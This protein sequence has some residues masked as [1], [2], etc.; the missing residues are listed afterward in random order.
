MS[1]EDSIQLQR[2]RWRC[3]RGLLELDIVLGR[4]VEH[5]YATLNEQQRVSFD[6]LLDLGDND[7]WDM[8]TGNK[9]LTQAHQREVLDWLKQA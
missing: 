1:N 2:L 3:R 7:L 9:E 8:V 6:E 5:R 4:F